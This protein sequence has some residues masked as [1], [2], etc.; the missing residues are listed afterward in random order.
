MVYNCI[1]EGE[2]RIYNLVYIYN[3]Y[4]IDYITLL[5]VLKCMIML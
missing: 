5:F 2:M 3:T 4:G 1:R